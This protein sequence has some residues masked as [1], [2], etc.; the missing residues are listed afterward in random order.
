MKIVFKVSNLLCLQ[1]HNN[2]AICFPHS[3]ILST[4]Y[5]TQC[6]YKEPV[7]CT[8]S[9]SYLHVYSIASKVQELSGYWYCMTTLIIVHTPEGPCMTNDNYMWNMQVIPVEQKPTTYVSFY[10]FQWDTHASVC[11]RLGRR[12]CTNILALQMHACYIVNCFCIYL[13]VL[14]L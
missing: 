13:V 12:T 3:R 9:C 10:H 7:Q 2:C 5:W 14:V 1:H 11:I 4:E 8:V 6:G